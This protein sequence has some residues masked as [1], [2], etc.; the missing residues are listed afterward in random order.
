MSDEYAIDQLCAPLAVT[1]SGDHAWAG[2]LPGSRAPAN[3]AWLPLIEQ[4]QRESRQTYGRPRVQHW[5][6]Q[7]GQVCGRHRVARRIRS[8]G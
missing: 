3:A 7:H 1:R 2:R 5:L 4:A 8:A 6:T